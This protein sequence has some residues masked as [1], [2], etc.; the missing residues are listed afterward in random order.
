MVRRY[1]DGTKFVVIDVPSVRAPCEPMMQP[2]SALI[3][4]DLLLE[5]GRWK[6]AG[7]ELNAVHWKGLELFEG[8]RLGPRL[9]AR[10]G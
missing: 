3:G 5:S 2:D 10:K 9:K 1:V 8:K 6:T 4:A 7:R